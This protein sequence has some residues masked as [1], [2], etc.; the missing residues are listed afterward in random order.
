MHDRSSFDQVIARRNR[1]EYAAF[2][3]VALGMITGTAW[4]TAQGQ[5]LLAASTIATALGA[6]LVVRTLRTRGGNPD[7][8][9][10]EALLHQADLLD[11]AARWYVGPLIPGVVG[12]CLAVGW[13]RAVIAVA[14]SVAALAVVTVAL[15]RSAARQLRAEAEQL[16]G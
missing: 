14:A 3:L 16:G 11:D 12:I 8:G 5:L 10:R 13:S 4:F 1:R 15:N 9:L 6:G 7:G 2:A